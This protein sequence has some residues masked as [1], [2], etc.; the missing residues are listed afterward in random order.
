MI[1]D[2]EDFLVK[3]LLE[4]KTKE[5]VHLKLK[6]IAGRRGLFNKITVPDINRPG[7]AL[8]GFFTNFASERIQLFG[9]GEVGYLE[10]MLNDEVKGIT[11]KG[12]TKLIL[13]QL[14]KMPIPCCVFSNAF[15]PSREFLEIAEDVN[16]PILQTPLTSSDFTIRI[17]R[18]LYNI[19]APLQNIHS[20]LVDVFDIGVLITGASG[21]GKSEVTLEL[22]DR[23]HRL[24]A[25]DSVCVSR[26]NGNTLIGKPTNLGRGHCMEIRGLGLVDIKALYG[27]TAV[28]EEKK[29]ELVVHLEEWEPTKI[30]ERLDFQNKTEKILGVNIPLIELPVKTGRN[31]SI[32][33]E[34]AAKKE[35]L[36]MIGEP[37]EKDFINNVLKIGRINRTNYYNNDDTY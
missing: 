17:L 20:N 32:L 24:I 3:D 4:L 2:K 26:L 21:I 12:S 33:I 16:C 10:K 6:C 22:I 18:I 36:K 25:D 14:L 15:L 5:S 27:I 31:V 11:K 19:L 23:G 37:I 1:G 30:Y 9:K 29:I 34:I 28:R 7:F 13:K 35:R 8:S